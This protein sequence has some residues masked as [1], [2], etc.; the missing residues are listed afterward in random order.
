M[1]ATWPVN[2]IKDLSVQLS[3]AREGNAPVLEQLG[4]KLESLK[5]AMQSVGDHCAAAYVAGIQDILFDVVQ[6]SSLEPA[7]DLERVIQGV[8]AL[9]K[10]GSQKDSISLHPVPNTPAGP[11]PRPSIPALPGQI[12]AVTSAADLDRETFQ[13]LGGFL[14]EGCDL[15]D[16]AEQILLEMERS[17]LEIEGVHKLF[18]ILHTIKGLSSFIGLDHITHLAHI[19]ETLIDQLRQSAI[20]LDESTSALL[21]DATDALRQGILSLRQAIENQQP[22]GPIEDLHSLHHRIAAALRP[23]G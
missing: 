2:L 20:E 7:E 11:P 14:G 9:E 23:S 13:L 6:K 8:R 22:F 21:F 3:G 18:R 12:A 1:K 10:M 19:S 15:L 5:N 17:G 16:D 4:G